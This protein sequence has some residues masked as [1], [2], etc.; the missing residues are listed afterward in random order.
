[1]EKGILYRILRPGI[2]FLVKVVFHPRIINKE[3]IPSSGSVVIA[4][5]HTKI[6]DPV[7]IL[8][9]T[10]RTVHFLAKKELVDGPLGFGFKHM[11]I[12]PVNRKIKDKS[13]MPAAEKGLKSGKIIGIFPEGTTEKGRGL[14]PFKFGAVKMASSTDTEIVPCAISGKYIPF[15]NRLTIIFGKPYKVKISE[16]LSLENEKLRNK[17]KD[18][19]SKGEN[20]GKNK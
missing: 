2:T 1:M 20:Y 13:V 14:L 19:I 8:S 18:L 7:L 17:I 4:S 16:D 11:G 10:K 15:I 9:C 12:I 5:N 6:F 3:Y